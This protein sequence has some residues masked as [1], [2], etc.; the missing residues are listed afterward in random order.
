MHIAAL[1]LRSPARDSGKMVR[2]EAI[3]LQRRRRLLAWAAAGCKQ[4]STA[5][6]GVSSRFAADDGG[7]L[8]AVEQPIELAHGA[9]PRPPA[10]KRR[11]ESEEV[12]EEQGERPSRHVAPV[13]NASEFALVENLLAGKEARKLVGGR[14]VHGV[15]GVMM[16][17]IAGGHRDEK[18]A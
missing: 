8:I 7:H 18:Q 12:P 2:S 6:D 5:R 9:L 15:D 14:T 10:E 17:V 3:R 1:M 11:E 4:R 13:G 16:L